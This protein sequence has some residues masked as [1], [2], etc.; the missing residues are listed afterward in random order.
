MNIR[1]MAKQSLIGAVAL[2][3]LLGF[4]ASRAQGQRVQMRYRPLTPQEI[5][6]YGLTN[7]TQTSGGAANV[8]IGQPVY[9][10]ALVL[11]GT[12]VDTVNWSLVAAPPGSSAVIEPG[13]LSNGIPTYD[14]G[15]RIGLFVAGRAM[16]RPDVAGSYD[17]AN[18]RILDYQVRTEIVLSNGAKTLTFTNSAYGGTYLGQKHYLCVLCHADKQA[19]FDATAHA[20]AFRRAI[21]GESTDHFQSRCISCHVVGY[22]TT[23][24]AVNGGFDDVATQVGWTFP[25]NFSESNWTSM[26]SNLQS[27]A[28]VQCENCHGAASAHMVS[29]GNTA[30]IDVSLSA[31]TCGQCHDSL[32]HHVKTFEWGRS[33]HS[34]G[35]V[36]RFSGSCM[37]CHSAKGFIET[38]DPY[39]VSSNKVPRSTEQEGIACSA[40]HDPHNVG[41]GDYQLRNIPTALLSN[42]VVI[43]SAQ[44]G[45]GVLC[46][47]CHHARQSANTSVNGTGSISPHHSTQGDLLAGTNG[48]QYGLIMPSSRHLQAV[49][50]SCVGCHMQLIAQTSYSNSNTKVGGHTFKMAWENV[51]VTE[52]CSKCHIEKD[53]FDF[54]GED[55]DRDGSVEGVQTE[56]QGLLED[57]GRLLPPIGS[58]QVVYSSSYTPAQRKAC[59]NYLFIWE[60]KSLGVHNPKYA[61]ALLQA[62]ID[63]LTGG[64]DVDQDGLR[65][66]WEMSNFGSLNAQLGTGDADNDGLSNE[67]E[68][69]LGTNPNS[70]DSDNDGIGDLAEVQGGSNP[71]DINSVLPP[72]SM[73]EMLPAIELSYLPDQVG[74]TQV[75][76]AVDAMGDGNGWTNVGPAFISSGAMSYQ[77]ISLRDSTQKYFRVVKP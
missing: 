42:G 31:G 21:T 48:F 69:Q 24:G 32:T 38:R 5:K 56:I 37:P 18:N 62:S 30:A 7:T 52:V 20:G 41:M 72:N 4:G 61:A 12:V 77:L 44:A 50:N 34:T 45:T 3:A 29:L 9:M 63:D 16:L 33:L 47:N 76:Q 55:Y 66:T 23:A 71:L 13:P 1:S 60:D 35:Y 11:T 25:T 2:V 40:C 46:I 14:G 51:K 49:T 28:N 75:F 43:T 15:D 6:N 74:V 10:E 19:N 59:W 70:G 58:T 65:D 68:E 67:M 17:F 73:M 22:D 57:L 8:G 54:G 36:F 27:V 26:P 53:T 64:I 39:Y